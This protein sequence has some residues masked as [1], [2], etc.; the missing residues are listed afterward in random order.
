MDE[1]LVLSEDDGLTLAQR[2]A[3]KATLAKQPKIKQA[4][5]YG[6]RAKGSYRLGSDIDLALKGDLSL[7]EL[8]AL[9]LAIDDL[10]LPYELDLSVYKL[11]DNQELL[12]HIE[13]VGKVFY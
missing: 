1:R 5:L 8:H 7:S 9:E 10:L 4:I 2:D 13:R 3:I 12:D 6:S 11:I